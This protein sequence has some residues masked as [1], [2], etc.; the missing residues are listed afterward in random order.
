MRGVFLQITGQ[1]NEK[2]L[3]DTHRLIRGKMFWFRWLYGYS[4]VFLIVAGILWL[5]LAK[6]SSGDTRHWLAYFGI[7]ILIAG[8]IYLSIRTSRRDHRKQLE[9]LNS[10]AAQ[11]VTL[12]NDGIRLQSREGSSAS[13]AWPSFK[14][15]RERG[16]IILVDRAE[17]KPA[18]ILPL[19]QLSPTERDLLRGTLQSHLG[20]AAS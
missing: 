12:E 8:V 4:R 11:F 18:V 20:A 2:E 1:L 10:R 14:R 13:L 3:M 15:W 9:K 19:S 5:T 7:W 16:S 6:L 17:G